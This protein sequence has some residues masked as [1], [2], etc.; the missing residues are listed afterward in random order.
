MKRLILFFWSVVL[1]LSGLAFDFGGNGQH[2]MI[3][4]AEERTFNV[5][6]KS[7]CDS[8]LG[9][10]NFSNIED[11][12]ALDNNVYNENTHFDIEIDGIYYNILSAKDKTL[13]VVNCTRDYKSNLTIPETVVYEQDTF[14]VTAIGKVI[15][16]VNS[17]TL[18]KTVVNV[19]QH[20]SQWASLEKV[21]VTDLD[22]WFKIKYGTGNN[23]WWAASHKYDLYLNGERVTNVKTP[24]WLTTIG[25]YAFLGC[26]SIESVTISNF[27]EYIYESA[28][29]GCNN[30]K[31]VQF[32]NSITYIGER[33]FYECSKLLNVVI[34]KTVKR[35]AWHSFENCTSL[36][37]VTLGESINQIDT[38]SFAGCNSITKITSFINNPQAI[39]ENCFAGIV[40]LKA[41]LFVPNGTRNLY[42]NTDGWN[43]FINIIELE[44]GYE[45]QAKKC[46]IPNINYANGKLTFSCE[47]E[48]AEC[49]ATISDTDIKTHYGNEI[50]LTATYT[51]SVYA[52]A[53]DYENS[54]IATATLCWIE[55]DPK[56]EDVESSVAH[57]RANAVLI[58][59]HDGIVS[60]KGVKA[61]TDIS[62]YNVSGQIVG[63]AKACGECSTIDTNLKSGS[64]VIV[65]I[66]GK[67]VK[68]V[69]Q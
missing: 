25:A 41:S 58:Q 49:V 44:G 37:E 33:A 46:S 43:D 10:E 63:K 31:E 13:E 48:G 18:P 66:G 55:A 9:C 16:N 6:Y 11:A 60:I 5:G 21:I 53:M 19:K 20:F 26:A 68:T 23:G 56:I 28:F 52:C 39:N 29:N 17:I 36:E 40:K 59:G 15:L 2:F 47:T 24:D 61:G 51:I 32:G 30:L 64:V 45:P 4:T 67:S 22:S 57:I 50:S 35:I 7:L 3:S 54:D 8:K 42:L 38:E 69:I 34:P 14:T 1:T 65:S 62:V 27:A 12:S